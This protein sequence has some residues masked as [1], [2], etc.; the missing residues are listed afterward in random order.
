MIDIEKILLEDDFAIWRDKFNRAISQ[1]RLVEEY[2]DMNGKENWILSNDGENVKWLSPEELLSNFGI[3]PGTGDTTVF[4][5]SVVIGDFAIILNSNGSITCKGDIH[6]EGKVIADGGFEGDLIGD[7]T[8]NVSGNAGSANKL[9]TARTIDG[10]PFDGTKNI[11]HYATC[12]SGAS[13]A[14]KEITCA[15]FSLNTGSCIT[16]T[17]NATNT[18]DLKDVRLNINNTGSKKFYIPGSPSLNSSYPDGLTGLFYNGS[19]AYDLIY[20]GTAYILIGASTGM[21]RYYMPSNRSIDL[22]ACI[23]QGD[24]MFENSSN[25]KN[26]PAG[27][28]GWMRVLTNNPQTTN[29]IKQ[30]W[31]R[32][33]TATTND[34]ETYTRLGTSSGTSFG[35]WTRFLCERGNNTMDGTLEVAGNITG[36]KNLVINGTSYVGGTSSFVGEATFNSNITCKA[37]INASGTISGSKIYNAVFNDY[38]EFFERGE[39]TEVGDIISLDINSD[40]EIYIKATKE[41]ENNI[42]GVH[43]DTYGHIVGG[44]EE[45]EEDNIKNF[46][47]V[48]L[49]GRVKTKVIGNIHRGDKIA[50]SDIAGVGKKASENDKIIGFAVESNP[51]EN[52]KLVKIKLFI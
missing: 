46:I 11:H 5:D 27:T 9:K 7:V 16:V 51:D 17:F 39:E 35:S 41:S 4:E 21:P 18:A 42:V 13:A 48:G 33:G 26:I 30:I 43:S 40:K 38:A 23:Y 25:I 28:N 2:P 29:I 31:Y 24:Y 14:V 47:P 36:N 37:N 32:Y 50:L 19:I 20:N 12:S 52:I 1:V 8:G 44:T 10:I 45:N 15:G 49:V 3:T 22:N 6:T 34:Y